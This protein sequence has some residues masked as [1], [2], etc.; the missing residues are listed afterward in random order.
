[1]STRRILEQV[2]FKVRWRR[3]TEKARMRPQIK[4]P[5]LISHLIIWIIRRCSCCKTKV[6]SE[7]RVELPW[8]NQQIT[9]RTIVHNRNF[10]LMSRDIA[11]SALTPQ[12]KKRRSSMQA[13]VTSTKMAKNFESCHTAKLSPR[14]QRC[15]VLRARSK[16]VNSKS[17][18]SSSNHQYWPQPIAI[19]TLPRTAYLA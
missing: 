9:S 18:V 2:S 8:I 1:M 6:N 15:F 13:S 19:M 7:P 10:I 12:R 3:W 14:L 5:K 11:N 16:L 4:L 17:L